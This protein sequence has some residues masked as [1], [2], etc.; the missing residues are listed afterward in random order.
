MMAVRVPTRLLLRA[1][2]SGLRH[3]RDNADMRFSLSRVMLH[4]CDG[5]TRENTYH[6]TLFSFVDA[7]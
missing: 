6:R 2:I 1:R 3:I 4:E 5:L 7:R